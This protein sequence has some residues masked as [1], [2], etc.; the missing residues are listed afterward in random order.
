MIYEKKKTVAEVFDDKYAL[1]AATVDR[2]RNAGARV[3]VI[4]PSPMFPA[5]AARMAASDPD[6]AGP[7]TAK[8][9]Y[10][11]RFDRFFRDLAGQGKI[12]YFPAYR[13]FCSET[14]ECRYREGGIQGT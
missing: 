1:L 11:R 10:S 14:L 7:G 9:N 2:L 13:A 12:A 5:P 3:V 4:G 8:A 6:L